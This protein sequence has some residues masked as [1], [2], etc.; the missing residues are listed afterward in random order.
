MWSIVLPLEGRVGTVREVKRFC[1]GILSMR[2]LLV[3]MTVLESGWKD[4]TTVRVVNMANKS[5][6]NDFTGNDAIFRYKVVWSLVPW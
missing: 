1:F 4:S 5:I 2:M 6:R 3:L